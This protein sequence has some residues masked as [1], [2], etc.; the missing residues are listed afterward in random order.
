[1]RSV[2]LYVKVQTVAIKCRDV[3]LH[4]CISGC[5][6]QTNMLVELP[7]EKR[8]LKI[9]SGNMSLA[10]IIRLSNSSHAAT[11]NSVFPWTRIF[12]LQESGCDIAEENL[13]QPVSVC[14]LTALRGIASYFEICFSELL[15]LH[16]RVLVLL[17]L[18]QEIP[19]DLFKVFYFLYLIIR[20]WPWI[21]RCMSQWLQFVS[22]T[23]IA[24]FI[25]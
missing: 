11:F 13:L 6:V 20:G 24:F 15:S 16:A 5:N 4:L 23:D 14:W 2:Q 18:K 12:L 9:C 1:M 3:G 25:L 21:A 17:F 10:I 7:T 19:Q 8:Q 22:I